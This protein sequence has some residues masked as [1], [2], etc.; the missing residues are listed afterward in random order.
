MGPVCVDPFHLMSESTVFLSLQAWR[1]SKS[2]PSVPAPC[3]RADIFAAPE[4]N[5]HEGPD[6]A[7]IRWWNWYDAVTPQGYRWPTNLY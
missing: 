6:A 5:P 4:I 1:Q 7:A 2:L 3:L